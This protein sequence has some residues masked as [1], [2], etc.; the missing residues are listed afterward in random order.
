MASINM[1]ALFSKA[2]QTARDAAAQFGGK[3][4]QYFGE[5]LKMAW[6]DTRKK[7]IMDRIDELAAMGFKRWQ[8]SGMDR[9]YIN[10]DRLGLE[11]DYYKSGNISYAEF[12]GEKI[13]NSRASSMLNTKTYI[14]LV[15]RQIVS[16]NCVLAAKVANILSVNYTY[17]DT[18]IA[19]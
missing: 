7:D 16:G 5:S 15:K 19:L 18:T 4:R 12:D 1:K 13:S 2:W 9:L 8:K 11:C 14:D 3:A 6:A 10:A 17:G